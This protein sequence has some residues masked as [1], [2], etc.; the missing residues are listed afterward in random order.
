[1]NSYRGWSIKRINSALETND[2]KVLTPKKKIPV[3]IT[4]QTAKADKNNNLYIY[5]D[6]YDYRNNFV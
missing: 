2:N 6:I 4:Y 5:Q 3:Y 1:M